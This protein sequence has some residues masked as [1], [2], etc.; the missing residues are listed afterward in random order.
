MSCDYDPP[1]AYSFGMLRGF[2]SNQR[3]RIEL[4]AATDGVQLSL[5]NL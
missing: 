2:Q 1:G 4:S 5:I 3:S